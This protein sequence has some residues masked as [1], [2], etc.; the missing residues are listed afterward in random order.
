MVTEL[1]LG[2]D[3][4]EVTALMWSWGSDQDLAHPKRELYY[5][6]TSP[7]PVWYRRKIISMRLSAQNLRVQ[8][9]THTTL[10]LIIVS[11][12]C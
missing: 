2:P 10:I 5:C 11:R 7:A 1:L 6:V 8:T 3:L 4:T 9:Q 12:V